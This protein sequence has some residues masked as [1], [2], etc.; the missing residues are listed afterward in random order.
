MSALTPTEMVRL[1][2]LYDDGLYLEDESA[3]D[4]ITEL[5]TRLSGESNGSVGW[6]DLVRLLAAAERQNAALK[7]ECENQGKCL[8][9]LVMSD[10]ERETFKAEIERL[11]RDLEASRAALRELRIRL[12]ASG[13]RPEECYEMSLID[14]T[15]SATR[16]AARGAGEGEGEGAE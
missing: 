11:T 1:A 3:C 8:A 16:A 12:H 9:K 13:R 15:L 5:E 7:I 2:D 14:D 6:S 10:G 4:E